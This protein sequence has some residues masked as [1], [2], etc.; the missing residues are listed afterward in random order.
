MRLMDFEVGIEYGHFVVEDLYS[1]A[2]HSED[3]MPSVWTET[4]PD[5]I[6][7]L[8]QYTGVQYVAVRLERWAEE[9]GVG[10][11][12]AF[13]DPDEGRVQ[14]NSG[15]VMVRMVTAG[16]TGPFFE[17]GGPGTYV[18]RA[19]KHGAEESLRLRQTQDEI[20]HGVERFLIRFWPAPDALDTV[21]RP[22]AWG[23]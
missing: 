10:V 14:L 9:P 8:V 7:F 19:Y 22:G 5:V 2:D 21:H 11:P 6:R 23:L 16:V 15:T 3:G 17:V 4:L 20:V 12:E 13:S 18:Y 1:E